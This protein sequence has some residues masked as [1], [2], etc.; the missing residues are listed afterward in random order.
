M[1][2]ILIVIIVF[3]GFAFAY[4]TD[5]NSWQID[6]DC[7]DVYGF[8][9]R[10]LGPNEYWANLEGKLLVSVVDYP[11]L[12]SE[13]CYLKKGTEVAV[14]DLGDQYCIVWAKVLGR[15]VTKPGTFERYCWGKAPAEREGLEREEEEPVEAEGVIEQSMPELPTIIIEP[16][17]NPVNNPAPEPTIIIEPIPGRAKFEVKKATAQESK[18]KSKPE[19]TSGSTVKNSPTLPPPPKPKK[20]I[21]KIWLL[22]GGLIGG[23]I[24]G[25][26]ICSF[27]KRKR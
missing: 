25:V 13:P 17:D 6:Q 10:S 7:Q 16:I 24:I 19:T 14:K 8:T 4:T 26:L 20:S 18:Q 1:K 9:Q 23:M 15:D 22:I 5:A 21:S 3:L 11:N 27:F 2:K 12:L